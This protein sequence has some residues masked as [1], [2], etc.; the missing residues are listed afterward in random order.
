VRLVTYEGGVGVRRDDGIFAT[1]CADLVSLIRGGKT[2]LETGEPVQPDRLLAPIPRPG[3]ILC[4]GINYASHK[5]E[6]PDAVFPDEPFFFSKLPSA[7]I[8]PGEPR[9]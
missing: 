2:D 7:V 4:S 5:E 6:N 9:S 3:K 1:G 8:G